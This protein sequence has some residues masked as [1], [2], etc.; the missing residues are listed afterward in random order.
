MDCINTKVTKSFNKGPATNMTI[1]ARIEGMS[2]TLPLRAFVAGENVGVAEPMFVDGD[3]LYFLTLGTDHAGDVAFLLEQD[4][5][6]KELRAQEPIVA[7]GNRH[8]GTLANPVVLS[9]LTS[10]VTAYP[11]PFTD[12][13]DFM[14][15]EGW[16]DGFSITIYNIDG[17]LID[18]ITTTRWTPADIPAGV[19]FATV[20]NKGTITTIK[21][22]KK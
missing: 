2:N 15:A 19:Y 6:Q 20:N 9:A 8:L 3:T 4:G 13:V 16:G 18:R 14:S 10:K 21:L 11:I 7:T 12:R 22:I 1:I 5:M 17:V